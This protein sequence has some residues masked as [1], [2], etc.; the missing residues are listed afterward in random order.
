MKSLQKLISPHK[1]SLIQ[2]IVGLAIMLAIVIMSFG[3]IFTAKVELDTDMLDS[4]N[5]MVEEFGGKSVEVPKEVEFSAPGMIASISSVGKI[6][7]AA[8]NTAKTAMEQANR[9]DG[10]EDLEKIEESLENTKNAMTSDMQGIVNFIAII[11]VMVQAFGQ[12]VVLGLVYLALIFMVLALP[13]ILAITF[14][15][16]LIPFFKHLDDPEEAYPRIAK[17][18]GSMF[19]NFVVLLLLKVIA[20]EVEFGGVVTGIVILCAIGFVINIIASRLN[21]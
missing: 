17:K 10:E 15:T 13:F 21:R 19:G 1:L 18:F 20:P 16:A 3:T 6:L 14:L 2:S 9:A 11:L 12:S 7:K 5:D 8:M 4:F